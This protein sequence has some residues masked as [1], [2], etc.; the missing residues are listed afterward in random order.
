MSTSYLNHGVVQ[1]SVSVTNFLLATK[2]LESLR[3]PRNG[4]VPFG[5]RGHDLRMFHYKRR[6]DARLFQKLSYELKEEY[7]N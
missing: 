6:V 1:L 3:E 4:P 5:Q 2:E 7:I